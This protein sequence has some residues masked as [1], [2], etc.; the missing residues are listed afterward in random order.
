MIKLSISGSLAVLMACA[1]GLI[2]SG[3]EAK[4]GI[5]LRISDLF[6]LL[7]IP[8]IL[9]LFIRGSST[10]DLI[11]IV[12]VYTL[13]AFYTALNA[14]YLSGKG[15]AIKESLQLFVFFLTLMGFTMALKTMIAFAALQSCIIFFCGVSRSIQQAIIFLC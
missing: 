2:I 1:A 12:T 8:L 9:V 13:Y 7:A 11:G 4:V 3:L 15:T 14:Y 6:L 10:N 5:R